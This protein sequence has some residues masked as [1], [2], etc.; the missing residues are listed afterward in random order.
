MSR[1]IFDIETNGFLDELNVCHCLVMKDL[2]T[3][4]R[5][6]YGPNT[7]IEGVRKLAEADF[8]AGHNIIR[9]DIP[10]LKKLFPWFAVTGQ[11]FDT[12]TAASLIWP[13]DMMRVKDAA[14]AQ[15]KKIPGN[16]VG[17][18][19]LEA[20]GHRLSEYKDKKVD[21]SAWSEEMQRYCEQDV[22]V[23]QMLLQLIVAKNYSPFALWLEHAIAQIIFEQEQNGVPF[24]EAA[25]AALLGDLVQ[26]RL[27]LERELQAMFQPFFM[28]GKLFTP[29]RDLAYRRLVSARPGREVWKVNKNGGYIAGAECQKIIETTF[30]PGSRTHIA[31]RLIRLR[32]WKP[33]ESTERGEPKVDEIVLSKL[34]WPEARLLTKYLTVQKRIGQLSEGKEALIAHVKDGRIHGQVLTN[35]AVTGRA[36]HRHPNLAQVPKVKSKK[37][38]GVTTLLK[39]EAGG[40]GF[41]FRSLFAIPSHLRHA[42]KFVGADA[43]G[44]EL[45]MLGH[46]MHRWDGGVYA[47]EVVEGDV[48]T[49]NM[50]AI[51]LTSRDTAKTWF[52]AFVYGAGDEKLGKTAKATP[53]EIASYKAKR[54]ELWLY[55]VQRQKKKGRPTDDTTIAWIIKGG[56]LRAKFL[57][58][59]PA[60]GSLVDAVKAK[61][62]KQQYLTGLDKRLLHTRSDHSALNTLLQSAGALVCKLWLVLLHRALLRRGFRPG[63]DFKQVLWIHDELQVLARTEIADEI[64]KIA[65]ETIIEA[66]ELFGLKVPLDGE[67]KVGSSWA[68]TH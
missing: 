12:F 19:S 7:V 68:S 42:W 32:G 1:Y 63:A 52:Y 39:G 21:F 10:A 50:N 24:D 16:M 56:L 48:H 54:R 40:W 13:V 62:K 65:R 49:V 31:D 14:L 37:I 18:H 41:E 9:F 57:K 5:F 47:R 43:S 27:D 67:Y 51:G 25:A 61:H 64:G 4:E 34:P 8:I 3:G 55:V 22:E 29:K 23:N 15:R 44:L 11:I 53:E 28:P 59:L 20:W 33:E 58:N 45:R 46:F 60:L 2:D 26:K 66:G 36:T 38:D 17:R 6:S 35:G 30:N